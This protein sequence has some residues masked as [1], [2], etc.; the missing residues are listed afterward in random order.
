[1]YSFKHCFYQLLTVTS[2]TVYYGAANAVSDITNISLQPICEV[3]NDTCYDKNEISN[4]LDWIWVT[5][6]PSASSPLIV[7]ISP[8]VYSIP[9]QMFC[10]DK[11]NVTFRG[12]GSSNTII[13]GGKT[14][15]SDPAVMDINNCNALSFQH[16]TIRSNTRNASNGSL[17]AVKWYGAG[18]SEWSNVVLEGTTHG[19]YAKACTGSN[20]NW[21]S[22]VINVTTNA[23]TYYAV[24]YFGN[25][26]ETNIFGSELSA[27]NKLGTPQGM[28]AL[29]IGDEAGIINIIGSSLKV[30]SNTTVRS[31]ALGDLSAVHIGGTDS[32]IYLSGGLISVIAD[33]NEDQDVG[34]LYAGVQ[35]WQA[36]GY[37]KASNVN[38]DMR[39]GGSGLIKRISIVSVPPEPDGVIEAPHQWP[40]SDI[41][42]N[43]QSINGADTFIDTSGTVPTMFIYHQGCS[44]A[45]GSWV[46]IS[47]T[48]RGE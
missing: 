44:G 26:G 31:W 8:G 9:D 10:E 14:N 2:L 40:N 28:R 13:T 7:D 24:A 18:S 19:W 12:S 41:P 4:M 3:E 48:C 23:S 11:G 46:S 16:L 36:G 47:G 20:H 45:G 32:K 21:H 37:I 29:N 34:A 22:S 30:Y 1:M 33:T 17:V 43:I 38:Y 15:G 5:R 35:G 42:P 27:I 39:P 6:Q 25:C